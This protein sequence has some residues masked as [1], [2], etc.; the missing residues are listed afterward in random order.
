MF[1]QLP[2]IKYILVIIFNVQVFLRGMSIFEYWAIKKPRTVLRRRKYNFINTR[3]IFVK[4][5]AGTAFRKLF[6]RR[7][8]AGTVFRNLFFFLPSV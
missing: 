2:S 7:T 4:E 8:Q 1:E 6:L 5:R 3:G